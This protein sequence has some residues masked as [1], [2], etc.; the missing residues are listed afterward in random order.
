MAIARGWKSIT[1]YCQMSQKSI[2]E[3]WEEENF[4]MKKIKGQ[5][6][7]NTN[8]IDNWISS[9]GGNNLTV[10]NSTFLER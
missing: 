1:R 6:T 8:E 2:I 4:P 3:L 7:I 9:Y 10:I 5:W